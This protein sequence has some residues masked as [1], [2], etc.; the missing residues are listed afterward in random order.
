M[1]TTQSKKKRIVLENVS[2]SFNVGFRGGESVLG[3]IV[4]FVSGKPSTRKLEAVKNV[5]L[6]I[7]E[8]E[9]VGLIG[10]N[11]SGKSTLLRLIAGI[12]K[13]DSGKVFTD[14]TV[15]YINGFNQGTRPRLSMRDNIYLVG[16]IM[17]LNRAEIEAKFDEIVEFSGLRDFVDTKVYQFSSGMV[18]RLN[19]S[20][21]VHCTAHKSPDI[22][23]L[24]EVLTAGGDQE[25]KDKANDKI[26]RLIMKSGASVILV[27]H[28][29]RY[30]L[31]TCS[32]A[33][34]IN[35]SKIISGD[36][37]TII[38]NYKNDIKRE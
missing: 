31:N 19:F 10:K 22:L 2:K 13:P 30:V 26:R 11:G 28:D 16:A 12:H 4:N 20:I 32:R 7:E 15:M 21:F 24:D 8:G 34:Y 27:S 5:S 9:I 17:G 37:T 18:T 35:N 33:L 23:L 6:Q 3:R 1:N 38:E 25:F 29:M 36:S 14:G